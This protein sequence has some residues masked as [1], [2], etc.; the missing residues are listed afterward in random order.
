MGGPKPGQPRSGYQKLAWEK[1]GRYY[2][3]SRK[4]AGRVVREYVGGGA[5]GE[6]AARLDAER[7]AAR[8]AEALAWKE[9]KVRLAETEAQVIAVCDRAELLATAALYAAGFH[10][11][12]RQ[13]RKRRGRPAKER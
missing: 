6:F 5:I 10:Q 1:D 4:V 8:Q 13:W 9:E 2:T 3:R 12:K 7:R 11:H